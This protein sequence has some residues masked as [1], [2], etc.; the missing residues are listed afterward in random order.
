M[1]EQGPM[2]HQDLPLHC[3]HVP[4]SLTE[5]YYTLQ[6]AFGC[7]CINAEEGTFIFFIIS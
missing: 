1:A 7:A 2:P 6:L 3:S 4:E 5:R